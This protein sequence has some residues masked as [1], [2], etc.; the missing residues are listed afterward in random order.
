[1]TIERLRACARLVT[2]LVLG[3]LLLALTAVTVVDVVGRYL[4]ASPLSGGKE[5]TEL[6][7]MGVVF[8]GLP[9]ITLDDGHVTADLFTQS[10]GRDLLALQLFLARALSG[11]ALLIGGWQLW[12]YGARIAGYGQVTL[13]LK[14]PQGPVAWAASVI[15]IVS[16]VVVLVMALARVPRGN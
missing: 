11:I 10:F 16:G 15:C 7:V 4:F 1:M 8:A 9:A 14:I 6:L 2:A 5:L 3:L 13:F 12:L